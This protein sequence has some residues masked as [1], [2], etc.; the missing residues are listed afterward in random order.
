MKKFQNKRMNKKK[1][2]MPKGAFKKFIPT[3]NKRGF[4]SE[5]LDY[6]S[7]K[8]VDYS[9]IIK[10]KVL[11]I[12]CAYGVSTL[13]ALEKG[14]RVVACD[15]DEGHIKILKEKVPER[16]K[17]Q[18]ETVVGILPMIDFME[19]SFCAILCSRVIHFMRGNDVELS[20]AKMYQWLEPAGRLFLTVDSPYTGVWFKEAPS[21]ERKKRAGHKWPGLIEDISIFF[22]DGKLPEG[23]PQ[24]INPMDHDILQRVCEEAGFIVEEKGF[25]DRWGVEVDGRQHAGVIAVKP[26]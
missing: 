17:A 11:D 16:Y 1:L 4:M 3:L 13:A 23:F 2:E 9:T 10:G 6:Y 14:G 18:L 20:V 25:F 26:T 5:V 24:F 15:M 19:N 22:P 8:F 21:Y 7:E 12:G